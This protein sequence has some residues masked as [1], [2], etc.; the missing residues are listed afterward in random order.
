[1]HDDETTTETNSKYGQALIEL[2]MQLMACPNTTATTPRTSCRICIP[3]YGLNRRNSD[4]THEVLL[5]F[6]CNLQLEL[7]Q[8]R[9]HP[10]RPAGFKIAIYGLHQRYSDDA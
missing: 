7:T 3:I 4:N 5:D 1:M 9:R 6:R 8:Q 2:D 10:E